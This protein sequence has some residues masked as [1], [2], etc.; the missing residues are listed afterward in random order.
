MHS[1]FDLPTPHLFGHRGASAHAPE[2]T[3]PAFELAWQTGVP[4]LETDC[5]ATRDGEVVI[6]H[7]PE[8]TR[9]TNG[10]GPIQE[11]SFA[12]AERL[13]A[14]FRFSPDSGR[15]FP[16]RGR[17]VRIPRLAEVI[18]QFPEARIN[19]EVKAEAPEVAEE[20]VRIVRRTRA[21]KRMLLA[22]EKDGVLDHLMKLDPGT[23]IGS[24]LGDV[25]AFFKAIRA[26]DVE[27]HTPRG[28]ALQIPL[29]FAGEELI[30]AESIAAAHRVGLVVH[31]WTIND[32]E[33]M[34]KLLGRGADGIMSDDPAE[35]VRVA[36]AQGVAQ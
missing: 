33:V 19:L 22:S 12:E 20:V 21:E 31:V 28:Q 35:L 15:T 14:G 11:L 32:P 26:G 6:L 18:D 16:Y 34:A 9:T 3:L 7:D 4:Y 5:H 27:R 1:Y 2:N 13:D 29:T 17:G 24:S 30:T 36:R 23:A 25:L 8:V 10:D